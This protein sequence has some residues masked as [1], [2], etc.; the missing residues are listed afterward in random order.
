MLGVAGMMATA[1]NTAEKAI[2]EIAATK[3][4]DMDD[5]FSSLC[6]VEGPIPID[7]HSFA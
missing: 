7:T 2:E 3:R 1:K 4:L 6:S 5:I